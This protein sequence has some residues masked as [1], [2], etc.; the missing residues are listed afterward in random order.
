MPVHT[1]Y[2]SPAD[3][4]TMTDSTHWYCVRTKPKNE[5][6]TSQLLRMEVGLSV[7]CPFIRFERAR[8]TGRTWVTEAMFPGYIFARMD[9]LT[10]NRHVRAIRGVLTIVGFGEAPTIVP[11]EIVDELRREVRDEET[12]I[13][14][15][16]IAIGEEVN[17]IV[18]PFQGLR[19]VVSRVLPARE[20]VAVLLEVLGMEREVEVSATALLPDLAHPMTKG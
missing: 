10:Q 14:Q 19:A 15:P 3:S 4:P 1:L 7:F 12:L 5:R 17:V 8:R 13:I 11:D 6:L 20:R 9:Y 18:G 2:I 16:Q